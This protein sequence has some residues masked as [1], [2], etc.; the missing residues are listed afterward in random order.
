MQRFGAPYYGIHRA[1]LQKILSG[2]FGSEHLHLGC[3]LVNIVEQRDGGRRWSSPTGASSTPIS[4]SARTACAPPSGAGSPAP[5]TPSTP[6]PAPSAASCPRR[7][8]RRCPTRTPSSSG[9][10]P[11]RTC[12]TTP[13]AATASTVNFFAVVETPQIWLHEA[14][15]RRGRRGRAR[16]LV[17]GLA[18]GGD[19][20]DPGGRE[21]DPLGAV[22]G[23][24]AAALVPGP[25]RDSRGR[26]PRDA[27]APRAG[28]QH[29]HRGR[30]RARR[31]ARR[32]RGGRLRDRCSRSSRHCG[33]AGPGRSSAARG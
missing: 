19:R 29:V 26:R 5:T 4:S 13:S 2:A 10:A 23:A 24:P 20:D 28:G 11:T 14:L 3:R 32:G 7:T 21:P 6:G 12:C 16:R 15:G 17:P 8:C 22:R 1:D 9:W 18:S 30:L 27:A 25:R 33:G 31:A